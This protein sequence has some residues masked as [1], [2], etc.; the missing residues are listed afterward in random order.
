MKRKKDSVTK[1]DLP[2][3]DAIKA[4]MRT[5]PPKKKPKNGSEADRSLSE[6]DRKKKA[7]KK[8]GAK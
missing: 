1:I 5:P 3:E 4:F 8:K 2:Y 6:G 7:A